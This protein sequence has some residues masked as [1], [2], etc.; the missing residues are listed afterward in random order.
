MKQTALE[1]K[2]MLVSEFYYLSIAEVDYAFEQG[3]FGYLGEYYGLNIV[4]FKHWLQIYSGSQERLNALRANKG[5]LA[6]SQTSTL[7]NN[8]KD[9]IVRN[10]VIDEFGKYKESETLSNI[11]GVT[12]RYLDKK[13]LIKA[14]IKRKKEI[15]AKC[16]ADVVSTNK[17]IKYEPHSKSITELIVA[18]GEGL[19]EKAVAVNRSQKVLVSELFDELIKEEQ[20]ITDYI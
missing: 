5:T 13:G 16:L 7:T 3:V 12:Y 6:I 19:S 10:Y 17:G 1:L 2:V 8:E 9:C 14:D 18:V 15:F 11:G 20:E 4:T